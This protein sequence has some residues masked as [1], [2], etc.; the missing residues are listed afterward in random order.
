MQERG[1][2]LDKL[3]TA[4]KPLYASLDDGQKHRMTVLAR[5]DG[6][7][8]EGRGHHGHHGWRGHGFHRGQADDGQK[9]PQ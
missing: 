5:L 8:G 1:A 7:F 2:A 3:A 6:R 4:A 9:Q